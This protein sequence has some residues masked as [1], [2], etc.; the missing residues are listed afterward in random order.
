[1][2]GES[3]QALCSDALRELSLFDDRPMVTVGRSFDR[4]IFRCGTAKVEASSTTE[5]EMITAAALEVG[6]SGS[7]RDYVPCPG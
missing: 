7:S 4:T 3:I 6:I 1:M 5:R 2:T